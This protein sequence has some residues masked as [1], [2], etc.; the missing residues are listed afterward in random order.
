MFISLQI[1][2]NQSDF[3]GYFLK[4]WYFLGYFGI[5]MLFFG[6]FWNIITTDFISSVFPMAATNTAT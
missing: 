2:G 5:F 3:L 4:F 6:K 1:C